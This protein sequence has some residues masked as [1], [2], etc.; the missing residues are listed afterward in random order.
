[1]LVLSRRIGEKIV[2][3]ND[4]EVIVTEIDRGKVRLAIKVDKKV[5]VF[6]S[7]LLEAETLAKCPVEWT[8]LAAIE[9]PAMVLKDLVRAGK[10]EERLHGTPS[11]VQI[12]RAAKKC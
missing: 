4:I 12:R 6:R 5:P 10:I 2:I 11:R 1:M 8:D 7:E 9:V 3:G